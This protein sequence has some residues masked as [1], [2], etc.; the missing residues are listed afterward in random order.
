ML[1][2]SEIMLTKEVYQLVLTVLSSFST[3]YSLNKHG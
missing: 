3:N 1:L 2:I